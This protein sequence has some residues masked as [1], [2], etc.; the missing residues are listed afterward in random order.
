[1]VGHIISFVLTGGERWSN[2][3]RRHPLRLAGESYKASDG[4]VWCVPLGSGAS[5][6]GGYFGAS[7]VFVG[8]GL[9]GDDLWRLASPFLV[10]VAAA[11]RSGRYVYQLDELLGWVFDPTSFGG[12]APLLGSAPSGDL[13][14]LILEASD[15]LMSDDEMADGHRFQPGR[16]AYTKHVEVSV[17]HKTATKTC[18][19]PERWSASSSVLRLPAVRKTGR[20]LQVPSCNLFFFEGCS[21]KIWAVTTNSFM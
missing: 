9:S 14:N 10:S 7:F 4:P 8:V 12:S 19:S 11:R 18:S 16:S 1:M 21:C 17:Q 6:S 2:K 15:S 20:S 5:D 13:G 3:I